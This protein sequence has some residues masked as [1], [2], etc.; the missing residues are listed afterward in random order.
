MPGIKYFPHN[1]IV[2]DKNIIVRLDLNVPLK[3]KKIQDLTRVNQVMPFLQNLIK[4]K[5]KTIVI[6]HLGI[7]FRCISHSVTFII[8]VKNVLRTDR[9]RN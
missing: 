8:S 1:L 5:A 3:N 6:S 2:E 4:K 9:K 7:K